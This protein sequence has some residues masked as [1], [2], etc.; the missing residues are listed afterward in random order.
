MIRRPPRSTLFPYTTLFRSFSLWCR[1]FCDGGNER[2]VAV[3]V[4]QV[5]VIQGTQEAG[6]GPLSQESFVSV[7]HFLLKERV[8]QRYSEVKTVV[9]GLHHGVAVAPSVVVELGNTCVSPNTVSLIGGKL[10]GVP[11]L[12]NHA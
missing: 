10:V 6:F 2:Y 5:R 3:K 9:E 11:Q 8:G 1:L 7:L 4:H 12:T